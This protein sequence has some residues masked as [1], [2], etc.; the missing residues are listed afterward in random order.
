MAK[1][2]YEGVLFSN[3]GEL[4]LKQIIE[5][6]LTLKNLRWRWLDWPLFFRRLDP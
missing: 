6:Q 1:K 2:E 3:D 4:S 5:Q